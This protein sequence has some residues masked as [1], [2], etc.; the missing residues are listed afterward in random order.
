MRKNQVLMHRTRT[1]LQ[2]TL[3]SYQTCPLVKIM[4]PEIIQMLPALQT[5]VSLVPS[6]AQK[7]AQFLAFASVR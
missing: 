3:Q 2:S 5:P 4:L 1:N 6:P 7:E